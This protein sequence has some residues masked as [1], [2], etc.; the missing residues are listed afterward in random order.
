MDRDA[1]KKE[2]KLKGLMRRQLSRVFERASVRDAMLGDLYY[3]LMTERRGVRVDYLVGRLAFEFNNSV[4]VGECLVA[5]ADFMDHHEGAVHA[6]KVAF[7]AAVTAQ[8]GAAYLKLVEAIPDLKRRA[9]YEPGMQQKIAKEIN[10]IRY[11]AAEEGAV[12]HTPA[13]FKRDGVR[14]MKEDLPLRPLSPA[15]FCKLMME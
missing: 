2:S 12:L 10:R 9:D 4:E 8:R 3:S 5:V 15:Q 6:Y 14:P 7:K 1:M 13:L 11:D